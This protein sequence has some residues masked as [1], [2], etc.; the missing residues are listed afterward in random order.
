MD[1]STILTGLDSATAVTAIL[2]AGAI[3]AAPGF[4][5]WAVKKVA[6]IFG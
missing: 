1:F 4:A 3:L 5:K 6:G 2:G